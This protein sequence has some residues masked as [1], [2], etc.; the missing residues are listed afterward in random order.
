MA[1]DND[2]NTITDYALKEQYLEYR[3]VI[4]GDTPEDEIRLRQIQDIEDDVQS[5]EDKEFYDEREREEREDPEGTFW[6][7]SQ[8]E[9]HQTEMEWAYH[10]E[11]ARDRQL[12]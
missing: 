6:R 11:Q 5:I 3:T 2:E 8:L 10:G 1:A 9:D 7:R 12:R 4:E